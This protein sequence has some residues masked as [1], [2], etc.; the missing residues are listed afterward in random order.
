MA[1]AVEPVASIPQFGIPNDI[2]IS[3]NL[4][5]RTWIRT[6]RSDLT[7]NT[8]RNHLILEHEIPKWDA[9]LGGPNFL[10]ASECGD[11]KHYSL[12]QSGFYNTTAKT[13][14][15]FIV[16]HAIPP[17]IDYSVALVRFVNTIVYA[18]PMTL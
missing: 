9:D 16:E 5:R 8:F 18:N 7:W 1:N 3:L 17:D 2:S 4:K 15:A 12:Y 13:V 14:D 11:W 10:C 6:A